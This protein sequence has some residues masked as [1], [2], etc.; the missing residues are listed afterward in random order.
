MASDLSKVAEAIP[1]GGVRKYRGVVVTVGGVRKV[2]VGGSD[3]F[4]TWADPIVVDD[5]DVVDVEVTGSAQGGNSVH[6]PS[7]TAVQPR[8]KTGTVTAVPASSPTINVAAG[9]VT[10]KAE[11]VGTYAVNDVVHLDWGAGRPRVI[12]RVSTTAAPPPPVPP[13]PVYVAESGYMDGPA[14]RSGTFFG[15]GGWDSWAG[16][17]ENV[18]QGNY[19]AGQLYGAWFYGGRFASLAGRTITKVQFRTG[20]R[21]PVGNHRAPAVLHFYAHASPDRPGGDVVRSG[22]VFDWTIQPGQGPAWIELP[23]AF[24]AAVVA[25]GGVAVAGD[26]YAGMDGRLAQADSGALILDWKK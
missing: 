19:G 25:G 26:P 16:G 8:P 7:R 12:G 20:A 23:V 17:G 4:A 21:R 18:F 3:L 15:P 22:A 11:F 2:N 13:A 9:G 14:I 24:G 5:G 10:Y 6:V 1:G